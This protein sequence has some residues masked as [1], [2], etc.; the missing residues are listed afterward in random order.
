MVGAAPILGEIPPNGQIMPRMGP[1]P[2]PSLRK[3][4]VEAIVKAHGSPQHLRVTAGGRIVPSEQSP[5]C[6]PRYGYSA[7]KTNGGLVKFAP[8]HPMGQH[9]QWTAATQ[10]GFVAQDVNG[11]LCQIVNGTILPL[12]EVDGALH[13]WIPAPNLNISSR[14][15]SFGPPA[16]DQS[17]IN[18]SQPRAAPPS[19]L[20]APQEPS[21]AAQVKALEL[22]YSR[23]DK[24]LTGVNQIEVLHIREMGK[25]GKQ[26]LFG[27]RMELVN[28]LDR[29][30]KAI[31]AINEG[32]PAEAPTSPKA[33]QLQ[34][35]TQPQHTSPRRNFVPPY[36][37]PRG[38][39]MSAPGP[40]QAY[41]HWSGPGHHYNAQYRVQSNP[42][43]H[44][45][46]G[47][48][49]FD[50]PPQ[51]MM[52][53]FD[54]QMAPNFS[55]PNDF[56]PSVPAVNGG[57]NG[58][59]V[60]ADGQIPQTDGSRSFPD[61][62]KQVGSPRPS[63]ALDIKVPEAKPATQLKSNLNPMSPAYKPGNGV[64]QATGNTD[65]PAPAPKSVKDRAPTPLSPLHQ[66]R[67]SPTTAS[68]DP[69][70]S[71]DTVS[72]TKKSQHLHSSSVSSF[73]TADFFPRN[74]REYSTR[75][76]AYPESGETEG[77]KENM[78]PST[79][80]PE[81]ITPAD[82]VGDG[83]FSSVEEFHKDQSAGHAAPAAPP[84]TP[85]E[86]SKDVQQPSKMN[87]APATEVEQT[88]GASALPD[89]QKNNLSPKGRRRDFIF[90]Q[91]P[92]D[93][94]IHQTSEASQEKPLS[95]RE[96][97][98]DTNAAAELDF[99]QASKEWIEGYRAGLARR[100]VGSDR[101]G[102]FLDGYCAGLLK[103][104]PTN[105]GHSNGSPAKKPIV[106]RR[107]SPAPMTSGSSSR[108]PAESC[109]PVPMLPTFEQSLQSRDTLKEAMFALQ[110]ENAVFTPA[111]EEPNMHVVAKNLGGW[112]KGRADA[113][114]A[115]TTKYP[116]TRGGEMGEETAMSRI[117]AHGLPTAAS[118]RVT[119][120]SSMDSSMSRPWP[121]P[122]V[123]S[124]HQVEW[125]SASS[126]AHAAGLASGYFAHTHFDGAPP[127]ARAREA[128]SDCSA[129]HRVMS[130]PSTGIVPRDCSRF[131]E[132]SVDG[133]TDLSPMSPKS[134]LPQPMSPQPM[135]PPLSPATGPSDVTRT[136]KSKRHHDGKS[137]SP[138]KAKFE[139]IAEKVG[140]KVSRETTG[141][142][143]SAA[144]NAE[145]PTSPSGK[146]RWRNVWRGGARKDG[147]KEGVK[148]E[149]A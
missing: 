37:Q 97:S 134:M 113:M 20:A 34:Q 56:V 63:R 95:T 133:P 16:Q 86:K 115:D 123:F 100:T 55:Y 101:V 8:N 121:A 106:S 114:T 29:I 149:G 30:R 46:F 54:G 24:E 43:I 131:R 64:L 83:T 2:T 41:G 132:V 14:G 27:K 12:S 104:Q 32:P 117:H 48:Q 147:G 77:D 51:D 33:M 105:I 85:V 71:E 40:Q 42:S 89:R 110:N 142:G 120:I 50:M 21:S 11:Q 91:Q 44:A 59:V 23:L 79:Q 5:L 144:G 116:I 141:T 140:I 108:L 47:P 76:H 126:V 45:A 7:I 18:G 25:T 3:K 136:P 109:E 73:Q 9:Q 137:P 53:S 87:V 22:E 112:A 68:K 143:A 80:Q 38:A 118:H 138:A 67:L 1:S 99:T 75:K 148:E 93:E 69:N 111:A 65:R 92:S 6:H 94:A 130:L 36:L 26:A 49:P 15:S 62:E 103:S 78:D 39:D 88:V 102:D 145:P 139:T 84:G 72:P 125:K 135:S 58:N 122:R 96:M 52:P 28:N 119:S 74:T 31:K 98:N 57:A 127:T 82:S 66:L 60:G 128:T 10:N 70:T 146:R 35:K 17:G 107:P 129:A 61:S 124:P 13:L 4:K 81:P 19:R 90:V